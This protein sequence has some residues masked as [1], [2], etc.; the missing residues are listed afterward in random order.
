MNKKVLFT[1]LLAVATM[2]GVS[3]QKFKPAPSFLKG[4]SEINIVFDFSNVKYGKET[5]AEQYKNKDKAWIDEWEG[6]R[7]ENFVEIFT[8]SLNDEL[9]KLNV[10]AGTFPNA[11]YTIIVEVVNCY[12]GFY[13][14]IVNQPAYLEATLKVVKTGTLDV[15]SQITLKE[16]QNPYTVAATPVDFDRLSLAVVEVGEEAGEKLVKALK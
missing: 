12:F 2:F 3:A 13:A 6:R 14:G 4:Q 10:A 11:E 7:R 1:A 8:G 15:L 16:G 9:K 5:Q